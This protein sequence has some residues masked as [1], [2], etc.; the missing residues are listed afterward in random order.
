MK[1]WMSD[2]RA[3]SFKIPT[4]VSSILATFKNTFRSKKKKKYFDPKK[5]STS[6][7]LK[8]LKSIDF[9]KLYTSSSNWRTFD[10][11][12][13]DIWDNLMSDLKKQKN[14]YEIFLI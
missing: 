4:F 1:E 10:M 13:L 6:L 3:Y 9:Q 14:E 12:G 7:Q 5:S 2:S 8:C 11:N